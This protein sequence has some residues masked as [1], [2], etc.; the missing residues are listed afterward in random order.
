MGTGPSSHSILV[1]FRRNFC[2]FN[3]V[4][5][6]RESDLFHGNFTMA[7]CSFGGVNDQC[8]DTS[9][10]GQEAEML[11]LLSSDNDMTAW[12]KDKWKNSGVSRARGR[13]GVTKEVIQ[14]TR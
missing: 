13:P 6:I 9:W 12:L 7:L 1:P 2:V 14:K 4:F 8:G 5:A 3:Q 10:A 11:H